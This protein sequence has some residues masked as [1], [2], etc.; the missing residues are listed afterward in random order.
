VYLVQYTNTS[1]KAIQGNES[2]AKAKL[3]IIDLG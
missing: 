1:E 3:G 2:N